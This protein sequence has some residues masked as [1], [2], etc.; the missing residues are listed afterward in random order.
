MKIKKQPGF[1]SPIQGTKKS[2]TVQRKRINL[3][4][5]VVPL[6]DIIATNQNKALQTISMSHCLWN[7]K[8]QNHVKNKMSYSL[9]HQ[10]HK[11][12]LENNAY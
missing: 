8:N 3:K 7:R 11:E 5:L 12:E 2:P 9:I 6:Y 10:K 4:L 1:H